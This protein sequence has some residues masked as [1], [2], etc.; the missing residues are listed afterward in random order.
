MKQSI[1]P[2][3]VARRSVERVG[4]AG[5]AG[6]TWL[7]IEEPLGIFVDGQPLATTMRTPGDDARLVLGH[8]FACGIVRSLRD[9]A[10][11]RPRGKGGAGSGCELEVRLHAAAAALCPAIRGDRMEAPTIEGLLAR[12]LRIEGGQPLAAPIVQQAIERMHGS[13]ADPARQAGLHRAAA[14]DPAG[15]LI[16]CHH[17]VRRRNAIEKVL[18]ELLRFNLV[19]GDAPGGAVALLVVSGRADFEVVERAALARIP[20]VVGTGSATS[21]AVEAAEATGQ[22]LVTWG[23]DDGLLVHAHP[24]R[25][26]NADG[27]VR[28]RAL[29]RVER[30]DEERA[31]RELRGWG[32]VPLPPD[33]PEEVAEPS[34][35]SPGPLPPEPACEPAYAVAAAENASARMSDERTPA[36]AAEAEA[37]ARPQRTATPHPGDPGLGAR[38]DGPASIGP[39]RQP[40]L[41]DDRDPNRVAA[42]LEPRQLVRGG[43][44][45]GATHPAGARTAR[46]DEGPADRLGPAAAAPEFSTR[47]AAVGFRGSASSR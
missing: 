21:L 24:W 6:E 14:F 45:P 5:G 18:G 12:T 38:G 31:A 37:F 20:V 26:G 4:G 22:T 30:R 13:L 35:A 36:V 15:G 17:D 27:K 2:A 1:D 28:L 23:D 16:C 40:I 25:I 34:A 8:L 9:V 7:T 10:S 29:P 39:G 32:S 42:I 41:I 3:G 46:R 11:V 44:R 43:D 19:G 33:E 47:V